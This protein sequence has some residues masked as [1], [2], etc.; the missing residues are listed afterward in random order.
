LGLLGS[1][2]RG[3]LVLEGPRS[4]APG[5][6]DILNVLSNNT[7]Y[8]EYFCNP[9]RCNVYERNILPRLALRLGE[10]RRFI[11]VLAGPRQVGK[12][13]VSEQ[14]ARELGFPTHFVTADEPG[15]KG[16]GWLAVQWE[17]ARDVA[18]KNQDRGGALLVMDEVQKI[19]GW[20][21]TVKRLWD[22]DTRLGTALRV[23]ILGSSPVLVQAGLSDSLA[24]RFEV[25]PISHWSYAEMR[26]AFGWDL[27]HFLFFGGY[28]GAAPLIGDRERWA[29]YIREALVETTVSRDILL[30][31]RVDKPALLRQLFSLACQYSGQ[32]LSY[33]KMV[34]QLQDAG[35]TTT[36][37]HYLRLLSG[38]GMV[39]G[40]PK[41]SGSAVRA[42]ASSPKLLVL[43]NALLSSGIGESL[44]V[45]RAD[46]EM[47]GRIV[48][49]AVGAHLVN[50]SIGTDVEI[51]YWR[52]KNMEV[53]YVLRKGRRLC[54]VEVK[55]GR[56]REGLP[57]LEEFSRSHPQ[58]RPLLVGT[59]GLPLESFLERNP[60]EWF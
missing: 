19:P 6:L 30:M 41:F 35:N 12:T 4:Q 47:W 7:Q 31:N 58:A 36:L 26:D 56:Q 21:E 18:R 53:D 42:R 25:I 44:D 2:C 14:V 24:G 43:N 10:P 40:L 22:E 39:T 34:G 33:N 55:S 37:A 15:I 1:A 17:A 54:A 50:A 8:V 28:P 3:T 13:T 59:G 27:D 20:S 23:L 46:G 57:G 48:E 60:E 52:E 5:G 32:I 11:Q 29:R 9:L 45:V 49:S 16:S 38:A 51:L